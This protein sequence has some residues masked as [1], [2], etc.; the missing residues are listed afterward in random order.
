MSEQ[1]TPVDELSCETVDYK[2]RD[3]TFEPAQYL[4]DGGEASWEYWEATKCDHADHV[5]VNTLGDMCA[6][7]GRNLDANG[8]ATDTCGG[9]V[10]V[11]EGPMMNY[12][13]PL[14]GRNLGDDEAR[15][16][17]DLPLCI[18]RVGEEYGMALTG[19]GTDLSWEICEAYMRLGYLPPVHFVRDLPGIAGMRLD[20]TTAW[21]LDGCQ[22][23]AHVAAVWAKQAED[24]ICRLRDRLAEEARAS[25]GRS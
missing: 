6:E 3:F 19:G 8:F 10:P 13:Y 25:R 20:A 14:P 21:V 16:I 18:V 15:T 17:V 22:R 2:P 23:S 24:V 9:S 7:E 1:L 4:P 11:A 5:H 12:F